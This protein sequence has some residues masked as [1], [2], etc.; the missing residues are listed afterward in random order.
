VSL[1]Q[2]RQPTRFTTNAYP[3]E[4]RNQAW[5][6]ALQRLSLR[7]NP[8]ATDEAG[9][10]YGELVSFKSPAGIEFTRVVST[11]EQLIIDLS[12][13]G[14]LVW[15][16]VLLEGKLSVTDTANA[17]VVVRENDVIYGDDQTVV[18][19]DFAKDHRMM[20]VR[21]PRA[22]AN[23]R[24]ELDPENGM[25]HIPGDGGNGRVFS[26]MLR[27]LADGAGEFDD[28]V[29]SSVELMLQELLTTSILQA[30]PKRALG[31]AA[32]VRAA[33]LQRIQQ[34][35]EIRLSDSALSLQD[36]A[37]EH[38][39]SP[40]YLQK[41][42]EET[43]QSFSHYLRLRRLE[44]C[45]LDMISPLHAQRSITE[46][47]FQWGFND[48]ASFSRSFKE[49]YG[50]S[51]RRYRRAPPPE[52]VVGEK[53][54]RGHPG[55]QRTERQR[56]EEDDADQD[57]AEAPPISD[58]VVDD[59]LLAHGV[60]HHFLPATPQ[61]IHWGYFSKN[62]KPVLEVNSGD[63]VTIETLTHH[64][65]D[66]HERMVAG[67]PGA[68]DIYRWTKDQKTVDRRGAGPMEATT[69]GRGAGEG[70][71][72]HICTGPIGIVGAMPG[73]VIELRILELGPRPSQ[74]PDFAGRC[75]GSN[76]AAF[77]GFHYDDLLTEPK[78]RE[79]VTIY[80]IEAKH[81]RHCAHAVY[82]YRWVPQTD[83]FGVVHSRIDYPGVL[84]DHAITEKNFDVLR[85][86]E[87]PLRP[88]F[89]VVGLA[90]S[91]SDLVDSV[92]PAN[93]GGNLDNWRIGPGAR[94]Y[95]PVAVP[96]GLL[97]IGDPHASQGDSELCGT[98]IECS[99]TGVVQVI[100]HRKGRLAGFIT[101]LDY[102]LIETSSDWVILGFSHP[103]YLKSLGENA[104][105]E[106]YKKSSIDLAMRDAFRK[107]RR[108]LMTTKNLS[109]D[110]AISLISVGVDFGIGQVV[111]GN[112][113][114]HAVIPKQLF[115]T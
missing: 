115:T 46:I 112:W 114:V 79:V 20:F 5:S 92:P 70:F 76:A 30:A 31:G 27:S 36:V 56:P 28:G 67:D 100:L 1:A 54:Q 72:V 68:E 8:N 23:L 90:P 52:T 106:V 73:D 3:K 99:M 60:R 33:Q 108:F 15:L 35:I 110:E 34:T 7:K 111:N 25:G 4:Q 51:P 50:V 62:L 71:G 49:I 24:Q 22:A 65:N 64:A 82:N 6:F 40:R 104:Q 94:V 113:G 53:L 103:D 102:P 107:V 59:A 80:E 91:H 9:N 42:F 89:G 95:L 44:R 58:V 84:V 47:L 14:D 78:P 61:T 39:V 21:I 10:F 17:T 2:G 45:R 26:G 63:Y 75:F 86:V 105:S 16:A 41:L 55:A 48:S 37:S 43:E 109:E 11:R 38:G 81:G 69:F 66:D 13:Q 83:P 57:G 97:S 18:K 74:N 93:F 87:I 101:D 32:G 19:L 85:N 96:G 98:A 88:H 12:E 77:W 29:L